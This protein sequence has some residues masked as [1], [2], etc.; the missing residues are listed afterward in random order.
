MERERE[1]DNACRMKESTATRCNIF[2]DMAL[3]HDS[4]GKH[5]RRAGTR[6][7]K[8][9]THRE[10]RNNQQIYLYAYRLCGTGAVG[11]AY[12]ALIHSYT[13]SRTVSCLGVD[14]IILGHESMS[15]TDF[16]PFQAVSMIF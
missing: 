9:K 8:Q 14:V 3:V 6:P 7:S 13:H 10:L 16:L 12:M 11:S 4:A 15:R 5:E 2:H 1:R